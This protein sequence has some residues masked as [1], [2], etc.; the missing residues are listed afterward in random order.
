MIKD[1]INKKPILED[2]LEDIDGKLV[3]IAKSINVE[4]GELIEFLQPLYVESL[5]KAKSSLN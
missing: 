3:G 5:K 4:V 1:Q 2:S